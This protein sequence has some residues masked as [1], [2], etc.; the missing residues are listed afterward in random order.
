MFGKCRL[1]LQQHTQHTGI[2][3]ERKSAGM[4]QGKC[5]IVQGPGRARTGSA[6]T[7]CSRVSV[8]RSH[9]KIMGCSIFGKMMYC[10]S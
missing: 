2:P 8:T 7:G 6:T 4:E 10:S 9:T 3:W 5:H 1:E